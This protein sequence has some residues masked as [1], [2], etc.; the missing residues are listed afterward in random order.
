MKTKRHIMRLCLLAVMTLAGMLE[1]AAQSGLRPR[2]DVDCDWEVSIADINWIINAVMDGMNYHPFY[3]YAVDVNGDKEITV[4]DI[5]MIVDAVLGGSL[6]AMPSYSGT[7][8]VLFIITE[9]YQDIVSKEKEDYIHAQWWIDNMG[10][11]GM[12][13]IGSP[14]EPRGMLIKGH[15][16]YTWTDCDKKS[17]RLKFDEKHKV[18]GMPSNRHWVLKANAFNW[19]GNIEDALPFEI[20][21]RMGLAWTPRIQPVE[22]VLN[23]QYIGMYFLYEKIRVDKERVNIIEQYDYEIE[24]ERVTGGWLL[25]INNYKEPDNL[26]FTEGN[27]EPFWVMPHSPEQLSVVQYQYIISLLLSA[28]QAIYNPDKESQ[29]WEQYIDIDSLAIYYLVQ[30]AVDNQEAFSGSC[31]I[32]KERGRD[33]KLIFGPLW[34]CDHSFNR[35][36]HGY[37]FNEFIYED[38][39][40]NWYSR[41][42][43]EITKFPRF[44]ERV[45]EQWDRFYTTVYPEMDAFMDSWAAR[46][47]QAGNADYVRWPQYS[48]NNTTARLNA[49]GK[50]AFRMKVAWLNSQWG[51]PS[52]LDYH[53]GSLDKAP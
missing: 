41:W 11:E 6:P 2:G 48:G 4:A 29:E 50:K 49:Y 31:Y 36:G 17:F 46:I 20:G 1:C 30:E 22:V 14:Q 33:T 15:G 43:G 44:Q 5:N 35:Y 53:Q 10:V 51:N 52:N 42:I 26:V 7:L 34:D 18:L 3:S 37:E 19:K 8:P 38:V 13:S 27:G 40:S 47:E 28:D 12:E 21:R 45:M 16:N 32:H 24:P 23:G 39:P 25:E 9:G